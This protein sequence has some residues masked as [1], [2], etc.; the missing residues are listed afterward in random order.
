M[1]VQILF[2]TV[3]LALGVLAFQKKKPRV[4]VFSK[5]A[6]Y[7]HKSIPNGIEAIKTI[8]LQNNFDVDTT[9][10]STRFTYKNLKH[11]AAVVFLNTTGSV[12]DTMQKEALKKYI[13]EG[14]GFAG[15]H[16]ATDTEYGWSWYGQLTGGYFE[17]HPKQQQAKLT[18]VD[19]L[20]PATKGL[21]AIW[22]HFDEWYNFKQLSKNI[23]P[24]IMVDETSYTG[25]KNGN[26]H[27][28]AWYQKFEGGRVFYT[29]LGHTEACYTDPLF[30]KHLTGGLLYAIG[31]N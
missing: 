29:G 19:S 17:S 4:L 11:Y 1:R 22:M 15:V 16:A 23:Q 30:L 18:I 2:L 21:P 20:H 9:T 10:D 25:G 12:F 26:F 27:P 8:G 13:H 24:L 28:M 3:L 7:H 31:K 14:G 6:G 5:T